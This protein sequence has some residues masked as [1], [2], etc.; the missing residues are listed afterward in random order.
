MYPGS[1]GKTHGERHD[2]RPARNASPREGDVIAAALPGSDRRHR[3]ADGDRQHTKRGEP[4]AQKGSSRHSWKEGPI[5]EELSDPGV[6]GITER[7]HRCHFAGRCETEEGAGKSR[8]PDPSC[9]PRIRAQ[10]LA[11]QREFTPPAERTAPASDVDNCLTQRS[12][13]RI[14]MA[15]VR[16]LVQE[17]RIQSGVGESCRR[18][19][20]H[21]NAGP[22][23]AIAESRDG[24]CFNAT[25][26]PDPGARHSRRQRRWVPHSDERGTGTGGCPD[27]PDGA[28]DH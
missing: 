20:L 2:T 28:A 23:D 15:A 4:A 14:T 24:R 17:H 7:R 22:N 18:S 5:A 1:S 19:D 6:G 27:Y 8:R 13:Q 25:H 16:L 3:C 9:C 26:S 10:L 21:N 11:D 12:A